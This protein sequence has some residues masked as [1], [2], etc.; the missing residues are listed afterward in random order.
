MFPNP[1][2]SELVMA[3]DVENSTNVS[4]D[5]LDI[6]GRV[7]K[8]VVNTMFDNGTVV[9]TEDIRNFQSGLYIARVV[10]DRKTSSYKF[11]VVH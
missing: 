1:A 10:N 8:S 2:S 6:N 3:F 9:L 4:I 7:V 5:I 11:N